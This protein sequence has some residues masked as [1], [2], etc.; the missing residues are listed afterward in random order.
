MPD[1]WDLLVSVVTLFNSIKSKETII[2]IINFKL[3]NDKLIS[4]PPW[5]P[6]LV[7]QASCVHQVLEY[8][9]FLLIQLSKDMIVQYSLYNSSND[10]SKNYN[11]AENE[12]KTLLVTCHSKLIIWCLQRES[13]SQTKQQI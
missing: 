12:K 6:P 7:R 9:Y 11:Q 13:I 5:R 10:N 3:L 2:I 4:G 1:M 8:C